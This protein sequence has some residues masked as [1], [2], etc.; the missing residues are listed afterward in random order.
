MGVSA[1]NIAI[2]N[3]GVGASGSGFTDSVVVRN[4]SGLNLSGA[5]LR[6]Y[7]SENQGDGVTG[8]TL[9]SSSILNHTGSGAVG[10]E[11]VDRQTRLSPGALPDKV[12]PV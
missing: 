6:C 10:S 9:D 8:G 3:G 2:D 1:N 7:V 11:I 12:K 5:A 4:G